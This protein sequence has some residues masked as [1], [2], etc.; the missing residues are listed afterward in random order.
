MRRV[1]LHMM[2]GI[3]NGSFIKGSSGSYSLLI[4][5]MTVLPQ[6]LFTFVCSYLMTFPLFTTRHNMSF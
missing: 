1:A 5:L 3:N 2:C 4:L 6:T